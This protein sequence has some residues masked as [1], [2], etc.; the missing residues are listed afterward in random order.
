MGENL[1]N[2]VALKREVAVGGICTQ[3]GLNFI[4]STSP[5]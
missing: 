3:S 1:P 2:L 4:A 5:F